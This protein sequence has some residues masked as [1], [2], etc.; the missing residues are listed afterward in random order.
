MAFSL[1]RNGFVITVPRA[2]AKDKNVEAGSEKK[3][4]SKTST[5]AASAVVKNK[6]GESSNQTEEGG[7]KNATARK[8]HADAVKVKAEAPL[9]QEGQKAKKKAKK[10]P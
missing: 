9:L 3:K 4:K 10:A 7:S 1:W 2:V 6:A 5:K 8:K